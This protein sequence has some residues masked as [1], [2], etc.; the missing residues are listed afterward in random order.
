[1]NLVLPMAPGEEVSAAA[2]LSLLQ[3]FAL[4]HQADF[5][6]RWLKASLTQAIFVQWVDRLEEIGATVQRGKRVN[7]VSVDEA[8]TRR[9]TSVACA[10]GS[11]YD[12]DAVVMA[13]GISGA[14]AILRGCPALGELPEFA[15]ISLLRG[16]DVAALRL[17]LPRKLIGLPFPS[18]V[19]GGGCLRS[20]VMW[21]GRSIT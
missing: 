12:A 2:A 5:D 16:V 4:E 1:M 10:D 18:N 13:V 9:V 19:V 21:A 17:W 14:K 11:V 15:G 6:V 3:F 20:Y 7:A 8:R